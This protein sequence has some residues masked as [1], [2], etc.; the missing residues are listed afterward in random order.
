MRRNDNIVLQCLMSALQVA[1]LGAPLLPLC[2]RD[3]DVGGGQPSQLPAQL[4]DVP[5]AGQ[6]GPGHALRVGGALQDLP[7]RVSTESDGQTGGLW[8]HVLQRCEYMFIFSNSL[9]INAYLL[10]IPETGLFCFLLKP[11]DDIYSYI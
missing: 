7:L 2:L 6:A 4:P 1:V 3:L 5:H 9:I 11:S 8:L 10:T